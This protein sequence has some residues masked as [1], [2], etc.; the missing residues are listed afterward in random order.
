M[1]FV[2]K[3]VNTL[4]QVKQSSK[5]PEPLPQPGRI[6]WILCARRRSGKSTLIA[7]LIHVYSK[8]MQEILILSP[9]AFIDPTWKSVSKLKN[10]TFSDKIDND[11]LENILSIQKEKFLENP[12]DSVLLIIDDAGNAFRG[13][14]L[15]AQ[16]NILFS[17]GRH[18]GL[19]LIASVQNLQ[20]LESTQIANAS[21]WTLWDMEQ[22][23]LKKICKDLA[24]SHKNEKE[25][26]EYIKEN[27]REK[28]SFVY[29]NFDA[30]EDR[31][32][33]HKNFEI[34]K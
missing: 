19:N 16:L 17:T 8:V 14:T 33:Y 32:V 30:K 15:R 5:I 18:Y 25:L 29:V 26:E 24:S 1:V 27:T 11:I 34:N 20:M 13:K 2:I 6:S 23:S 31:D 3:P 12:K 28:Y 10:V 4:T 7:N 22:R 9:T 21:Q